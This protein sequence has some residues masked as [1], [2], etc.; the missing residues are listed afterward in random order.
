MERT[1]DFLPALKQESTAEG[2]PP[3]GQKGKLISGANF[4]PRYF[5]S[6]VGGAVGAAVVVVVLAG[7]AGGFAC[8]P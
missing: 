4:A 6:S 8:A 7:G 3:T 1:G 2:G 5:F